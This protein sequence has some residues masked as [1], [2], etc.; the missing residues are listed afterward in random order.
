MFL[1]SISSI[2]KS[3]SVDAKI[4][5]LTEDVILGIRGIFEDMVGSMP[6]CKENH[7]HDQSILTMAYPLEAAIAQI[8]TTFD[9]LNMLLR[10]ERI[11][12]TRYRIKDMSVTKYQ[13]E[14]DS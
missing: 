4:V 9:I 1:L 6:V 11:C 3:E 10:I 2:H 7:N 8:Y 5:G 13:E 12:H 14:N